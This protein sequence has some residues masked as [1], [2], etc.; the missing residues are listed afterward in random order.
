MVLPQ[1]HT[2]TLYWDILALYLLH[3]LNASSKGFDSLKDT[4]DKTTNQ[5]QGGDG[6]WWS[7]EE[8]LQRPLVFHALKTYRSSLT[9]FV[10]GFK[11]SE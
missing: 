7:S 2:A 5:R 1:K 10:Q 4:S 3:D 9:L 11:I 6:M 8:A